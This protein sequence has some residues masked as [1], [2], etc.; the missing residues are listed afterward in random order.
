MQLPRPH[1]LQV[2]QGQ[3][4]TARVMAHGKHR[5]F[6]SHRRSLALHPGLGS[7]QV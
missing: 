3:S 1:T 6:V 7:M 2:L 4:L 5:V